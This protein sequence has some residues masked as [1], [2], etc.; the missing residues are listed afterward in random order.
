MWAIEN[1]QR[2]CPKIGI[3]VTVSA[4]NQHR[5]SEVL[6][7]LK[8]TGVDTVDFD[9]MFYTTPEHNRETEALIPQLGL[10]IEK[11]AKAFELPP[12]IEKQ[13]IPL[14]Q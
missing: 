14:K 11:L 7:W 13:L 5:Y 2:I 10:A 4:L 12:Q 8:D 6:D 3:T 1:E 9:Y